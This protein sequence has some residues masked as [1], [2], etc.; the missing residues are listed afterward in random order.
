GRRDPGAAQAPDGPALGEDQGGEPA[1][2]GSVEGQARAP[3]EGFGDARSREQHREN[4]SAAR[5]AQRKGAA[6]QSARHGAGVSQDE[7]SGRR[8]RGAGAA[9]G[10]ARPARGAAQK[11]RGA[12]SARRGGQGARAALEREN[13]AVGKPASRKGCAAP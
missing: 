6:A 5:R 12:A 2:G 8:G 1:A 9:V 3:V 7:R 10:G 13:A 4:R 11:N